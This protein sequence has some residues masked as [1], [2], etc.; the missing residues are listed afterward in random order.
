[1]ET[2]Y[3]WATWNPD[4]VARNESPGVSGESDQLDSIPATM[5]VAAS[6]RALSRECPDLRFDD[7]SRDAC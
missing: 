6:G 7:P 2:C 4:R 1:V 3:A 5:L